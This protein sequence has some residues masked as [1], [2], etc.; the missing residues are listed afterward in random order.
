MSEKGPVGSGVPDGEKLAVLDLVEAW[1]EKRIETRVKMR[2][3]VRAGAGVGVGGVGAR[4]GVVGGLGFGVLFLAG[5][6]A[7]VGFGGFGIGGASPDE[8]SLGGVCLVGGC[9]MCDQG[10]LGGWF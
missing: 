5:L 7:V 2:A 4:V 9:V 3:G 1:I 10:L 6:V 8:A